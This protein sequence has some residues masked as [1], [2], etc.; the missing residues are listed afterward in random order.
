M[1]VLLHVCMYLDRQAFLNIVLYYMLNTVNCI[2]DR[3]VQ[4]GCLD[5]LGLA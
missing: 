1:C 2:V 4:V 3:A 5:V